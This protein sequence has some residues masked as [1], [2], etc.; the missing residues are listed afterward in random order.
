GKWGTLLNALFEFKKAYDH[1]VHLKFS[2]PKIFEADPKRYAKMGLKDLSDAMFDKMKALNTTKALANAFSE[3]PTPDM[4]PVE[5]YEHLVKDQVQSLTLDEIAG[6]TV[7]T[8][9]VPYPPGIPLLM[10]GEN[11]GSAEGSALTYLKA[12]EAFDDA[13]PEFTHDIH[14]VEV[15]DGK[16]HILCVKQ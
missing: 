8:G 13:F 16:Y 10:P 12:L 15:I 2:L 1:N 14:G 3:L 4:T 5:A 11:A 9:V 7:A 6:R